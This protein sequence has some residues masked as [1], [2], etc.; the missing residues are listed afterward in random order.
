MRGRRLRTFSSLP[1]SRTQRSGVSPVLG[2]G[3][4][5][6][7]P[8]PACVYV[9]SVPR[10]SKGGCRSLGPV[11]SPV[12]DV[13]PNK[14]THTHARV[15]HGY[16]YTRLRARVRMGVPSMH[17]CTH[18]WVRGCIYIYVWRSLL[19]PNSYVYIY[20]YIYTNLNLHHYGYN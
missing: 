14:Y 16:A 8:Q 5:S 4:Q 2:R 15:T 6:D 20:I 3:V 19:A 10:S 9:C 7:G 12:R 13:R 18:S 11:E 1:A 17:V